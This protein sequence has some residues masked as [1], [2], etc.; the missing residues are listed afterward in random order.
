MDR[1]VQEGIRV[2]LNSIYEP[3]FE[4][5]GSNFGFRPGKSCQEAIEKIKKN[6]RGSTYAIEGDIDGAYDSVVH[7]K[8]IKILEEKIGDKKF[9]TMIKQL[10]KSGI[11]E[12][13]IT[14]E[15]TLGIP[16]GGIASPILFNI[17]MHKFDQFITNKLSI[18]IEEENRKRVQRR[19]KRYT[20]LDKK[21][22]NCKKRI[23]TVLRK[24]GVSKIS[25]LREKEK[26]KSIS[27]RQFEKFKTAMKESKY[28]KS[29]KMKYP[30]IPANL[31]KGTAMYTR[32][33]D[34]WLII[35]NLDRIKTENMKLEIAEWLRENLSLQLSLEK[36]KVTDITKDRAKF[37]GFTFKNNQERAGI[38]K[39]IRKASHQAGTLLPTVI[40]QRQV[41][42][43][44]VDIDHER[45]INRMILKGMLDKDCKPKRYTMVEQLSEAEI[46]LRFRQ[47]CEGLF[48]YY[49]KPITFKSRLSR[50]HYIYYYS[51]L[52]TLAS[53]KKSSIRKILMLYGTDL[54]ISINEIR[55]SRDEKKSPKEI[56]RMVSFPSYQDAITTAAKR[57]ML[58]QPPDPNFMAI[59]INL[60]SAFKLTR[61]C[62]IC[63]QYSS[64][65]NPVQSHHVR[66]IHKGANTQFTKEVMRRKNSRQIIVCKTCHVRIHNGTY[67][68]LRLSEFYNPELALL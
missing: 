50:Y 32:Y 56:K 31:R 21:L 25:E 42:G 53:R 60:R 41:W 7:D 3:L 68:G 57:T 18:I 38:I 67:N 20:Q 36:S 66:H 48:N 46:V 9:L 10:H 14:K 24:T 8:I 30:S 27:S 6:G 65:N 12:G 15:T 28:I 17:Y 19:S 2:I 51:C 22:V 64:K 58:K 54:K 37:L 59:K 35:T 47:M 63:G 62:C 16:Q 5:Q 44:F 39:Y 26:S 55:E 45:V 52:H 4:E 33:A 23:G 61:Y 43:L 29:Q 40:R 49:L 1:V 13:N 34:D 11:M